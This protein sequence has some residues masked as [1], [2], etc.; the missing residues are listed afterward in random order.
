MILDKGL[1]MGKF[2]SISWRNSLPKLVLS[3]ELYGGVNHM[4]SLL[5]FFFF[6]LFLLFSCS[7]SWVNVCSR[8]LS[9]S[10]FS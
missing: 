3:A 6:F 7:D 8:P 9:F 10:A 5:R 1:F 4:M 2:L